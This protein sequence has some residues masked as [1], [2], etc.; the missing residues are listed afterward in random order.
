MAAGDAAG[1]NRYLLVDGQLKKLPN[2]LLSFLGSDLLSWRGKLSL[3]LERWRT[4]TPW[5]GQETLPQHVG[6]ESVHDFAVRRAGVEVAEVF[7][8]AMVT[9]IYAGDPKLLSIQAAFP[10]VAALERE[11]GS[12]SKGFSRAAK[13]RRQEAKAQGQPTP[14]PGGMWSFQD[15]LRLLVETLSSQL[16]T[17]PIFGVQVQRVAKG[18]NQNSRQWVAL[19]SSQETWTADAVVLACPAYCQAAL[20]ADVDSELAT[21]ISEIP[22]NRVAVV[23]LGYCQGDVP[24]S[25]DG[26]GYIAP[27]R[28]RRDLLG[29]QWCSSIF[30]G[31]APPGAVLL[32]AMC[33]GWNRPDIAGWDDDKL[34]TVVRAELRA[35]MG[36]QA[37]PIF[38]HI[39]RWDRAIP[40]YHVGHL[41]RVACD[42]GPRR[43]PS[44][45]V[46]HGECLPRRGAQRLRGAGRGH[47]K[48]GRE[49]PFDHRRGVIGWLSRTEPLPVI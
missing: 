23:A 40:Q 37:Q 17:R 11:F 22:Y 41:E 45:I 47:G 33:G 13:K 6:D 32:R 19:A 3:L 49:L 5:Q 14:R 4:P 26:F 2:G 8:D 42:R 46:P 27:Q 25:L 12:V 20:L 31:R 28:S 21:K 16:R 38:H 15:G 29:V 24:M 30:P 48:Q 44:W 43:R 39:T 18:T 10:R 9:G 7:A 34:L 35:A 1:K 36:I